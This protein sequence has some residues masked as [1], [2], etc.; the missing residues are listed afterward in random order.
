MLNISL[1]TL[2]PEEVEQ[3]LYS[4]GGGGSGVLE[5]LCISVLMR[6]GWWDGLLQSL[7]DRSQALEGLE[8][9]GVPDNGEKED[10]SMKA[11]EDLFGQ[12]KDIEKLRL[13]CP[14]LVRFEMT[15]LLAKRYGR[16]AWKF[17]VQ[18]G[19]WKGGFVPGQGRNGH[20]V[21]FNRK[22]AYQSFEATAANQTRIDGG[23]KNMTENMDS[24]MAPFTASEE[25]ARGEK[26]NMTEIMDS[27]MALPTAGEE[28]AGGEKKDMTDIMDSPLALSTAGEEEAGGETKDMT[29]NMDSPVAPPTAGEE[30]AGGETKN[31]TENMDSLITPYTANEEAWEMVVVV[32]ASRSRPRSPPLES[33]PSRSA[34]R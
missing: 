5:D 2:R 24:P 21:L 9:V 20:R 10:V 31:V 13:A 23:K 25:E 29:E 16:I 34:R 4:C 28:E 12:A 32:E 3:V 1:W 26:S 14:R 22:E 30:E 27:P 6:P 8:I 11:A 15:I 33:R 19:R 7:T 18:S 17:D